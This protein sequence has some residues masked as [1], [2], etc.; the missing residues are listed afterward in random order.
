MRRSSAT[1]RRREPPTLVVYGEDDPVTPSLLID[2]LVGGIPHTERKGIH[3]A[4][5]LANVEQPAAFT[6]AVL[7]HLTERIVT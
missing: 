1:R 3:G 2:A 7:M 4:A 5:Q 6:A